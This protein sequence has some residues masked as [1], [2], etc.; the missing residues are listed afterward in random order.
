MDYNTV[1]MFERGE[2]DCRRTEEAG[3][4]TGSKIKYQRLDEGLINIKG[5]M[6]LKR[7]GSKKMPKKSLFLSLKCNNNY[8]KRTLNKTNMEKRE[9]VGEDE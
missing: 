8:K 1:V 9:K 4:A 5:Q 2:E 3:K 6:G 7:R